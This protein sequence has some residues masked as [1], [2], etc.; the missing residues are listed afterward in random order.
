[1]PPK[2]NRRL[3][4]EVPC[5]RQHT[6]PV[7]VRNW[8]QE[9]QRFTV[10]VELVDPEATSQAAQGIN[11]HSVGTLELPPGVERDY[12][13]SVYSY[14]E[15]AALVRVTFTNSETGEFIIVD[16]ALK[17]TA[18][19]SLGTIPLE[20]ACRQLASHKFSVANP[21]DRTAHFSSTSAHADI[22]FSP[23]KVEV[24]PRSEQTI[25][26]LYRPVEEGVGETE[27]MLRSEE[28]GVY[29]Y[30]VRWQATPAALDRTLVLK[31]P[32]GSSVVENFT[33][34]HYARQQVTYVARVEAAP[35]HKG[36][37][38]N[39][40]VEAQELKPPPAGDE[41]TEVVVGV[42]FQPSM[43]GECRALLVVSGAGGGEFKAL[44]TGY[45]Q[46]PQP[47]GPITIANGKQGVVEFRNPFDKTTE[48]SLQIDNAYFTVA[49]RTQ[50]IDP[51][52]TVQIAINF[53][54]DRVQGGRLI[55][56]STSV[57]TP[58]IFFLRGEL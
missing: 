41:G 18:P 49:T 16:V 4:S 36:P 43:L 50:T 7:P 37:S 30:T 45:A 38:D 21:L 22:R 10:Q 32:L 6:Q 24:A 28:L 55:V 58:W 40:H 14:R 56:S 35:S 5:K 29:P 31:A 20:A 3:E 2:A 9:R 11:L 52:K 12:K 39:F 23:D 1:L 53:K 51:Y 44:L 46:P 48:F 8:L 17:F 15:G 47:K 26:L 25:S 57:S 13:F 19:E 42:R 34:V 33:F 27:V 54:S